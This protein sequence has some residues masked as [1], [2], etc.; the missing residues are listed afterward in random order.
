MTG[1]IR[2]PRPER[3]Y[4]SLRNEVARDSRVSYRAR[5]VLVRLLSNADGFPMTASDLA[6]EGREGR[7]AMLTALRELRE[8]GY[9]RTTKKQDE[10]GRWSTQ[11]FVYDTPQPTGVQKPDSGFPDVGSPDV[12]FL[13]AIENKQKNTQKNKQT[14]HPSEKERSATR[15]AEASGVERKPLNPAN[16][17]AVASG[18][19]PEHWTL[20]RDWEA[21][22]HTARPDLTGDLQRIA[23]TFKAYGTAHT[24]RRSWEAEWRW[25]ITRERT[26]SQPSRHGGT[27]HAAHRSAVPPRPSLAERASAARREFER[28][29]R[30]QSHCAKDREPL[31]TDD[32]PLRT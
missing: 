29:E 11:T 8:A 27:H 2:A 26:A 20:P 32:P 1:I 31:G 21:W 22:A 7:G 4:T 23:A 19:L 15:S 28:R 3:Q 18:P 25:W 30:Q 16:Q 17:E 5:G 6:R 24:P 12:G 9:I 13:D 10:H 14:E